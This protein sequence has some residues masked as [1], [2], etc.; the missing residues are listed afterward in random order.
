MVGLETRK[1]MNWIFWSVGFFGYL[2]EIFG[3]RGAEHHKSATLT[4]PSTTS[5][6]VIQ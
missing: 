5:F 3:I 1:A 6:L 4:Q 2:G